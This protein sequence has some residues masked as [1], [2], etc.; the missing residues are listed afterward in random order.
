MTNIYV[1]NLSYETTSKEL[2]DA[3]EEYGD[4]SKA[5]V[6]SDRDSGRSKGFAFVEMTSNSDAEN[7]INSLNEKELHGRSMKVNLAKPRETRSRNW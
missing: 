5:T 6:I 3:F 2:Q 7:A 4:V 1:G